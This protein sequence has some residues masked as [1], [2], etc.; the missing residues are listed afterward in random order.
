[1]SA[2]EPLLS[3]AAYSIM[4]RTLFSV[5][6]AMKSVL[7]GF[8][9]DK[10]EHGEYLI[11]L[12]FTVARDKAAGPPTTAGSPFGSRVAAVDPF[13]T[14]RLFQH[15]DELQSHHTDFP[16]GKIHFNHYVKVHEYAGIDAE[17]LL[18]LSRRG[19]GILCANTHYAI[20]G[21]NPFLCNGTKLCLGNLG[22]I[23]WQ[24]KNDSIFTATASSGSFD[25]M[26]LYKLRIL[27]ESDRVAPLIK[28]VFA[29]AAETP[30]LT[31]ARHPP[32]TTYNA[33]VYEI[34]C[35][36][37][38]PTFST[39]WNVLDNHLGSAP[40]G[41]LCLEVDLSEPECIPELE[42]VDEPRRR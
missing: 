15:H 28:I 4:A 26:D 33:V 22:L 23:L 5:F 25:A 17:S 1:M 19:A 7:R 29:L 18:L 37:T 13:L 3:E 35:A 32:S 27:K 24:G 30:A 21:I 20:D 16:D 34:W 42:E 36:G 6:K 41:F 38:S 39:P 14:E 40:P 11:L 31:V 2:S 9:I 8:S 10:G 12:L